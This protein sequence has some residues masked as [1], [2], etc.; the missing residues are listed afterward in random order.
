M[1]KLDLVGIICNILELIKMLAKQR[2]DK[3]YD[4]IKKDGAVSVAALVEDFGVSIETVRKDLLFMEKAGMLKRV[5][6]GA[7]K[8]GEMKS[9]ENLTHR[10]TENIELK[11][12]LSKKAMKFVNEN[13]FIA[14]DAGST[15]ITFAEELKANFR[16]LTVVTHCKDVF[17]I[18]CNHE[19]FNV[20]LCAGY[21]IKEENSFYGEFAINTLK[22]LHVKKAFIFNS[23][24]SLKYGLFD[25][26]KDLL[27]IQKEYI[28]CADEI[29]VLAD[30][31]KFEKTGLLKLCDMAEDYTY[32]T[33]SNLSSQL[34]NMYSQNGF[35]VI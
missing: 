25:F 20:I 24:I 7:V 17:D 31:S 3:I 4:L 22:Q 19:D 8:L 29:F 21:Y 16:K 18:L 6:G 14:V 26:Q 13:D 1:T 12:E 35:K 27:D 33:D 5:H 32:I 10:N 28:N 15:A 2:Q 34:K 11:R 30:S 23:A 9:F